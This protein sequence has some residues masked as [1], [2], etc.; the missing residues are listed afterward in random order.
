MSLIWLVVPISLLDSLIEGI[1]TYYVTSSAPV[2]F[3]AP[4]LRVAPF[5]LAV[6]PDF[7]FLILSAASFSFFF[8]AAALAFF[9]L[10]ALNFYS[11]NKGLTNE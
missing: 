4:F 3:F 2:F 1:L 11:N 6:T 8:F 7:Y 10:M 9:S 5:E